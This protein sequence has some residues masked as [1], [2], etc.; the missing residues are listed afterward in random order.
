MPIIFHCD[1]CGKKIEAQN[2]AGGKWGKCPAC[3][4]KLY[5]PLLEEPGDELAL[6][7]VDETDEERQQRLTAEAYKLAQDI[8]RE[9]EIP[10]GPVEPAKFT[11][12]VSPLSNDELTQ[13]IVNYLRLM[14]EGE[15][16][17]AK[18]VAGVIVPFGRRAL[19]TLDRLA[20]ADMAEPG[21]A[22]IPPRVLSGLIRNLRSQIG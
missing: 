16:E 21:L 20:V 8:L 13:T 15:L 1:H 7:P 9:T 17:S 3:K 6:A 12:S 5:V 4:N 14:A 22:H 11:T 2:S 10:N 19:E 18:E